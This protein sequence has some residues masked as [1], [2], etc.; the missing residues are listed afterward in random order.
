MGVPITNLLKK[1]TISFQVQYKDNKNAVWRSQH[2]LLWPSPGEEGVGQAELQ[3]DIRLPLDHTGSCQ[4][5]QNANPMQGT[6]TKIFGNIS[7]LIWQSLWQD[8][9]YR[10]STRPPSPPPQVENKSRAL[11]LTGWAPHNMFINEIKCAK[12]RRYKIPLLLSHYCIYAR[13]RQL[14]Y[15]MRWNRLWM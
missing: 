11:L 7:Y 3:P 6:K 10:G 12:C 4:S 2:V 1:G 14:L 8:R 9:Q 13:Y 15:K 5:L